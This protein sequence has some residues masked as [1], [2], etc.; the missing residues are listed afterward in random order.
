MPSGLRVQPVTRA[1][2]AAAS[3][4]PF[5]ASSVNSSDSVRIVVMLV[6]QRWLAAADR[7][8]LL[9]PEGKPVRMSTPRCA[10]F[11]RFSLHEPP[12]EIALGS[13]DRAAARDDQR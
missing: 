7:A 8:S 12:T 5:A 1:A 10:L 13:Q 9:R 3:H 11:V 2:S 4:R 6:P